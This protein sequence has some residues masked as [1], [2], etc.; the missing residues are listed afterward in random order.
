MNQTLITELEITT[1]SVPSFIAFSTQST[2]QF[3]EYYLTLMGL[4]CEF[5]SLVIIGHL[6]FLLLLQKKNLHILWILSKHTPIPNT[7]EEMVPVER[8]QEH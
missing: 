6:I 2:I 3:Y 8:T 7:F 4:R 1:E 5:H